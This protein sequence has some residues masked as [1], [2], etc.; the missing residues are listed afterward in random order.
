MTVTLSSYVPAHT[1]TVP[2]AATA[3]TAACTELKAAV[4][5]DLSAAPAVPVG[6]TYTVSG[7]CAEECATAAFAMPG[8]SQGSPVTPAAASHVNA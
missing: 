5:H 3:S 1:L 2:R 8:P 7:D 4:P 6:E